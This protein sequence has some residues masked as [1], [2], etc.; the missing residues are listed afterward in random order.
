MDNGYRHENAMT[1]EQ[2]HHAINVTMEFIFERY[3]VLNSL[4]GYIITN[5]YEG[6]LI[7]SQKEWDT[8][9]FQHNF[10]TG[11]RVEESDRNVYISGKENK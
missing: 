8:N 4:L 10:S 6:L 1:V 11:W 7:I 5:D 9:I 2:M 3:K